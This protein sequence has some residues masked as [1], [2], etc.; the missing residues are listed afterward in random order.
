MKIA[1]FVLVLLTLTF[2]ITACASV[3]ASTGSSNATMHTST[4]TCSARHF[5]VTVYRGPDAGFSLQGA[6]K[7]QVDS[8]GAITGTLTQ[9]NG[10]TVQIAGQANGRA[11]NLLFT[12]SNGKS[13]FGVGTLQNDIRQCKGAVGGPEVGPNPADSGSWGYAIGG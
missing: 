12:L 9:T 7:L 3:A 13:L 11:I 1:R 8:S 5:E 4:F 6:L 2:G 10:T